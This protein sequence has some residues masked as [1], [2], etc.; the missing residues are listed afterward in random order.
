MKKTIALCGLVFGLTGMA[1]AGEFPGNPDRFPSIGVN[2]TGAFES[3]DATV[4]DS[5]LS[6]TQDAEISR[7]MLVL[8]GR[9]PVSNSF[10]I[11]AAIGFTG[12][13]TEAQETPLLL[14]SESDT[15]GAFINI[16]LRYYIH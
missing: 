12:T 1:M 6:A 3:G 14:G 4:K 15:S 8:D 10:T 11:N 13:T 5:G 9:L 16:G 7:G 2:Y